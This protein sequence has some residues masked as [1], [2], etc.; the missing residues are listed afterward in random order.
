MGAYQLLTK[1]IL[2]GDIF[3]SEIPLQRSDLPVESIE[4]LYN[5]ATKQDFINDVYLTLEPL[6]KYQELAVIFST[7]IDNIQDM[8]ISLP[9]GM[10][11]LT[12]TITTVNS[13][14]TNLKNKSNVVDINIKNLNIKDDSI[15]DEIRGIIKSNIANSLPRSTVIND[16][17]IINYK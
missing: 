14:N 17:N 12:D 9:C 15:N 6:E 3:V 13:I 2:F 1:R 16:I 7:N 5:E 8:S 10:R 11:N 4:I